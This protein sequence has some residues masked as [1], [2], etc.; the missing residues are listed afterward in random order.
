MNVL[1]ASLIRGYAVP[2]GPGFMTAMVSSMASG[3]VSAGPSPG[4]AVKQRRRDEVSRD[5]A[6]LHCKEPRIA[7]SR[8]YT[9]GIYDWVERNF[10]DLGRH[11]LAGTAVHGL[12][13][14]YG[15]RSVAV[16]EYGDRIRRAVVDWN[17][18]VGWE[19]AA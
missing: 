6:G 1:N 8:V 16:A 19:D 18:Q 10:P 14:R 7:E 17:W 9:A 15:D 12:H 3:S 4:L 11:R 13:R 2:T 5:A